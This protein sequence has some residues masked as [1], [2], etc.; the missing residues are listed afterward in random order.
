MAA[1]AWLA[2]SSFAASAS[3][4]THPSTS[5]D[6]SLGSATGMLAS[7][8]EN[9]AWS[10]SVDKAAAEYDEMHIFKKSDK[11]NLQT[12][13]DRSSLSLKAFKASNSSESDSNRKEIIVT[14]ATVAAR[15]DQQ[16]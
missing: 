5:G 3:T 4:M 11:R 13:R 15:A 16:T 9:A 14:I 10:A 2:S 12:A 1:W 8:A 6:A 7:A